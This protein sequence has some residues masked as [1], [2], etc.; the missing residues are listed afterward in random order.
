MFQIVPL[1]SDRCGRNVTRIPIVSFTMLGKYKV[2]GTISDQNLVELVDTWFPNPVYG[3]MDYEMRYTQYQ[4]FG[5][6]KSC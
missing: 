2:N 3:D 4:D 5:G 1:E 6:V